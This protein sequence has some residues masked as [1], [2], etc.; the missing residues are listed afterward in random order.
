MSK[1]W[2]PAVTGS[3]I[4]V[5]LTFLWLAG[6]HDWTALFG[7]VIA[8][9]FT[10]AFLANAL[11]SIVAAP[12][13]GVLIARRTGNAWVMTRRLAGMACG[14]AGVS[15]VMS[16]LGGAPP[17]GNLWSVTAAHVAMAAGAMGLAAFGALCERL[18]RNPL[19]AGATSVTAAAATGVGILIAGPFT[20]DIPRPVIDGALLASP[21]VTTATAAGIDI[22]RTDV[23]YRVSPLAHVG[24]E[25]SEWPVATAVYFLFTVVC[26]A[27]V[28]LVKR[29]RPYRSV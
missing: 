19:D 17:P 27:G 16:I 25:Y 29:R 18:F 10:N 2:W 24:T 7:P 13:A 6:T 4:V 3:P 14:F 26:V 5:C 8:G 1:A 11:L 20:A 23:L 21:L 15:L 28:V 12:L 9:A 22:L